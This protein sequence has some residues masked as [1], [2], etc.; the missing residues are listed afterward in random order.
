MLK[1]NFF[2]DKFSV[3]F[4]LME[5]P[6]AIYGKENKTW[7]LLSLVYSMMSTEISGHT[8]EYPAADSS[9]RA[10]VIYIQL[11]VHCL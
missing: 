2:Q 11:D 8:S 10:M 5:S 7:K 9:E 4:W 1:H 6:Y 3:Q